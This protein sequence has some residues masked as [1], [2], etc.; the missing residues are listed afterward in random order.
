MKVCNYFC[1]W[2]LM[3]IVTVLLAQLSEAVLFSSGHRA[4]ND[5]SIGKGRIDGYG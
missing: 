5:L 4:M 2:I 1:A 3:I